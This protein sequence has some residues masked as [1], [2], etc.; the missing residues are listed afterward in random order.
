MA[1]E[2]KKGNPA[3]VKGSSL[4]PNGRPKGSGRPVSK[5]RTMLR[6]L[7]EMSDSALQNIKDSVEGKD[8]D[9]SVLDSSK[10][11]INTISSLTK[12]CLQEEQFRYEVKK[13]NE[14]KEEAKATGT[15]GAPVKPRFSTKIISN[16]SED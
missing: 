12:S 15:H 10:Y 1:E 14:E 16:D 3:M 8:I 13:D 2:K 9:K 11:I 4:N 5:L 6:K 7:S